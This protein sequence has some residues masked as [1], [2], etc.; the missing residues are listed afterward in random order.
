M[1]TVLSVHFLVQIVLNAATLALSDLMLPRLFISA[2]L[3]AASSVYL[4]IALAV[5]KRDTCSW[6]RAAD[7]SFLVL[8]GL[9]QA[10]SLVIELIEY[11]PERR[12]ETVLGML[13]ILLKNL[14]S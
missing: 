12:I 1:T 5:L 11:K 8:F 13:L 9:L 6:K 10:G 4:V 7:M 14:N 2:L 3:I